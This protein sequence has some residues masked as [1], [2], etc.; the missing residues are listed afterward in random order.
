MRRVGNAQGALELTIAAV[1]SAAPTTPAAKMRDF[2]ADAACASAAA[3]AKIDAARL[4]PAL[5]LP[6]G[7]GNRD[8][9]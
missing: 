9:R 1:K 3:G 5:R 7:A 6:R 4:R 2:Q 8:R